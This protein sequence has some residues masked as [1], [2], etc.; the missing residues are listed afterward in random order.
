MR[1]N[2]LDA[3]KPVLQSNRQTKWA[4]QQRSCVLEFCHSD[5]SSSIDSN[6]HK[7]IT[8]DGSPHVDRVWLVK[9]IDE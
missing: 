6:S 7:I 8:I 4:I 5:D 2:K 9:T 3:Y 1:T